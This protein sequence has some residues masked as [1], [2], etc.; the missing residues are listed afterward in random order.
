MK[1]PV[2]VWSGYYYDLSPER[3]LD[4]FLADGFTHT[5][6]SIEHAKM[7]LERSGS[8]EK[9]GREYASYAA[10]LEFSIPQGHLDM[11]L[12]LTE[13]K[14]LDE[15]KKWLDLFRAIGI[16]EAVLHATGAYD[17]SHERQLALRG[18]AV[19]E[20]SEHVAGTGMVICLENL[21]S[22]PM[23][24]TADGILELIEA[25]GGADNLGICLD[26][27]HQ[28]RVFSH[29]LSADTPRDF[30][31]KAGK[32]LKALHVH[33]N[34]G[35]KDD[36]LLPFAKKGLDWKMFM[37]ALEENGFD[38]IFNLEIL[39]ENCAPLAVRRMKLA[40]ALKLTDYLFSEEFKNS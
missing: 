3:A 34:M 37:Q 15:L 5:E 10:D 13:R 36:H 14:D 28:H 33:D 17:E 29:G 11:D 20:L 26:I 38:G 6:L 18:A 35:D 2:S 25:A 31:R 39:G 27:G 21:F 40:Y 24:W 9:I 19:R 12:E 4:T 30:I 8:V 7:L 22:K 23:V 16:K 1:L 32:R